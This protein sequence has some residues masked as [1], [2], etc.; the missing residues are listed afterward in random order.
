VNVRFP[1]LLFWIAGL[2][3]LFS[4]L[5]QRQTDRLMETLLYTPQ[6][7]DDPTLH[8]AKLCM[9]LIVIVAVI[10]LLVSRPKKEE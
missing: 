2:Y 7:G 8:I 3:L 6:Y 5:P 10:K 9:F 1:W 4:H